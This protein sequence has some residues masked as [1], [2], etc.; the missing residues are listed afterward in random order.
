MGITTAKQHSFGEHI[1]SVLLTFQGSVRCQGG[2]DS[3][4][5]RTQRA[6]SSPDHPGVGQVLQTGEITHLLVFTR[7]AVGINTSYLSWV[8][9]LLKCQPLLWG[10]CKVFLLL[11]FP[12]GCKRLCAH[13]VS[14][15]TVTSNIK[16]N[17]FSCILDT[18]SLDC[19][20]QGRTQRLWV[21]P[22]SQMFGGFS[23]LL[24]TGA[25]LCF[26]AYGIQAVME[27]EPANDNVSKAL[28]G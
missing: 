18:E 24:W 28:F 7:T 1:F 14:C 22:V 5:R 20:P 19:K 9:G 17:L 6:H 26:L 15:Q 27:D 8:R 25:V 16:R 23:M 11:C 3:G 4:S 21:F 12:A 10:D 2:G 13:F